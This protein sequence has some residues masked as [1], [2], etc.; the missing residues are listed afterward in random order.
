MGGN[1]C[2][3]LFWPFLVSG[4]LYFR[5]T[6]AVMF[7]NNASGEVDTVSSGRIQHISRHGWGRFH[8]PLPKLTLPSLGAVPFD[9]I[10]ISQARVHAYQ[11]KSMLYLNQCSTHMICC[12][13]GSYLKFT[14]LA[15]PPS[16]SLQTDAFYLYKGSR[17]IVNRVGMV[18]TSRG[19]G[20][21]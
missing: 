12:L 2:R 20:T 19:T 21:R 10:S 15:P 8:I 9:I 14:R 17:Y 6:K 13:S 3:A 5:E 16:P 18:R 11:T 4:K 7:C 1:F